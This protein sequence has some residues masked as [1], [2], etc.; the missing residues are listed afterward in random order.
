MQMQDRGGGVEG[1]VEAEVAQV[2][3]EAVVVDQVE[4]GAHSLH[5]VDGQ[6]AEPCLKMEARTRTVCQLVETECRL[7]PAYDQLYACAS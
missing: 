1:E 2:G 3:M 4:V 5:F 7:G 6:A